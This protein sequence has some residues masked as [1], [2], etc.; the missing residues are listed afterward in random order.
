MNAVSNWL[1]VA[2]NRLGVSSGTC[3]H[4]QKI[5]MTSQ[6]NNGDAL[7][8]GRIDWDWKLHALFPS[9]V[10]CT[11]I[12]KKNKKKKWKMSILFWFLNWVFP[13][14]KVFICHERKKIRVYRNEIVQST[15]I[16]CSL[17]TPAVSFILF[18]FP[19]FLHH[20]ST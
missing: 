3:N 1:L 9:S 17:L 18:R 14:P 4:G 16:L 7:I 19:F 11:G 12:W 15:G 13:K 5:T 10:D 20:I 8:W 6:C 2:F